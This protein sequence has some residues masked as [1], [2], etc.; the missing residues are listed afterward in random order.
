MSRIERGNVSYELTEH[1]NLRCS[2]CDHAS[3]WMDDKFASLAEFERDIMA[4]SEVLHVN[5]IFLCGGEP[6]LHPQFRDFLRITKKSGI[7]DGTIVISN[8][9]LLHQMPVEAWEDMD[10]MLVSIY[11]GVRYRVDFDE[12]EREA[13]ARGAYLVRKKNDEFA[14]MLL[15]DKIEDPKLVQAI[16]KGCYSGVN[17]HTIYDGMYYRCSRAHTLESR[18]AKIG[19][20]VENRSVDGVKIHGNPNL[21]TNLEAYLREDKPLKACEYC[22]G[23][24]GRSEP[25]VQ[26]T[27]IALRREQAEDHARVSEFL[28]PNLDLENV[29][30]PSRNPDNWWKGSREWDIFQ[31]PQQTRA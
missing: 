20:Q 28:M 27:K 13:R 8:A 2:N 23:S 30:T 4:L 12:V 7:A 3:P 18:M 21:R 1:C 31:T 6:L 25:H 22:I 11:P 10:A 29:E 24:F 9:M 5:H 17:C 15:N 16:Y 19:K 26:L 14:K